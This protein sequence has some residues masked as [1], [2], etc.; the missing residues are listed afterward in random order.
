MKPVS[1]MIYIP[2]EQSEQINTLLKTPETTATS[3]RGFVMEAIQE[4]IEKT[5]K[6]EK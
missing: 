1:M 4:K 3:R 2:K 5:L 6:K